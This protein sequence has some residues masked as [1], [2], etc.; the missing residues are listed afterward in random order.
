MMASFDFVPVKL[1]KLP[2][3]SNLECKV[4]SVKP[5]M[6]EDSED[7]FALLCENQV[8]EQKLLDR[9][10]RTIF[11]NSKIYISRQYIIDNFFDKGEFLG[12]SEDDVK[13]IR[14][15]E[16]PW[17][18]K[19]AVIIP[20]KIK[21]AADNAPVG[22]K[23]FVDKRRIEKFKKVIQEYA[24]IKNDADDILKN[25]ADTGKVDTKKTEKV[26]KSIQE[27]INNNEISFVISAINQIRSI[28]EYLHTHC[29][30]VAFLNGLIG[31]WL[32]FDKKRQSELVETGLFHD[33]G[34]I[35]LPPEIAQKPE[36]LAPKEFDQVKKHP[37]LSVE[38]L[39]KSGMENKAVLEGVMQHHE[40][41]NGTGYPKG[42]QARDICEYARITAIS[43][44][45]DAMV[46]KRVFANSH[47]PFE[48]LEEFQQG[49]YSEL[50]FKYVDVFINCMV[51]ELKGKEI[52]MNDGREAIVMYVNPR[53][54][55][56]PMVEIDGKVVTTDD[57]LFCLRM[58]NILG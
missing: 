32:D 54:L 40:R 46:T 52:I 33:L 35:M 57:K 10:K 6:S 36:P 9:L 34:K 18:P 42:L 22:A 58:K 39:M 8:I 19:K 15:H 37:V 49:S 55:L 31:N 51:E 30:N 43:D 16:N 1:S 27:Q 7:G 48:I 13:A 47:S 44:T 2:I 26:A 23:I 41:V 24:V 50:D 53:N 56:Y 14:N 20:S 5:G 11:P 3:G 12:Y 25:A 17:K 28:D 4:Y 38:M 45:Y 21:P 29:I